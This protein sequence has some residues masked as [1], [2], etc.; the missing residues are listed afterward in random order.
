[1]RPIA[2]VDGCKAGWIAVWSIDDANLDTAVFNSF[3]GLLSFLPGDAIVAVDMPIG[4]PDVISGGGRGPEQIVRTFLGPRRSSVFAIPSRA[5]V[6]AEPGP[7]EDWPAMRA[8]RRRA[9]A[10]ARETSTP[11][12]GLAFQSFMLFP[13]IREI[14]ALLRAE[15]RLAGRVIESHPEAAFAILNGKTAMGWP[16][17]SAPGAAERRVLL[18]ANG[19]P[20]EFLLR[21]PPKGAG[22]DDF[23][24]ACVLNLVAGRRARGAAIAHSSP[25]GCDAFGLPIAIWT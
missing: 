20:G 15:P 22:T 21:S 19:L 11:P 14:D 10:V 17:T 12:H 4:L 18:A 13:R 23:L 25:P 2:G 5:A 1:M 16:K 3:A 8:A 24:D 6:H 7:F 9:D